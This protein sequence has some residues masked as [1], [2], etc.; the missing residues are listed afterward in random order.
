MNTHFH[1]DHVGGNYGLQQRYQ[2]PVA[3][4]RLDAAMVNGRDSD[5]CDAAWLN[6]PIEP[7]TVTHALSDGDEIST[8][9]V[10]L[11]V[12]H[13][14][15][16]TLGH[17]AFYEPHEQVLICGDTFH[18]DDVAWLGIF[19]QGSSA[20]YRMMDTL[21]TLAR[22]PIR[23][24]CSGHGPA[25]DNPHASLDAARRRYE[26]WAR[27]PEKIAW[28]ACKRI[29]TYALMLSHG[30]T[31]E[32]VTSYLLD[33]PWFYDYTKFV[34][35]CEPVDFIQPLIE[36]TLRAKAAEWHDGRLMPLTPYRIPVANWQRGPGRPIDWPKA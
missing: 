24:A 12:L 36:E 7:Y 22:L 4:H 15:G 14:P 8:G 26:K 9:E 27:D 18:R 5:V 30:M 34:F 16:H 2:L 33:C 11:Q 35:R 1:G 13:T 17:I 28:H 31:N 29:F 10:Q 6:Q 20:L 3:A 32:E 23:Y 21:D 19:R 25:M